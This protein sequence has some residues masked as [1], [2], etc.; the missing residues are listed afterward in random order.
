MTKKYT[1]YITKTVQKQI[2][3]LPDNIADRIEAKMLKL[4]DEPRPQE[5]KKLKGRD[6]YRI[7]VGD[8]R[9][10]YDVQDEILTVEVL[11][12]AHRKDIYK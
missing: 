12:V 4:E 7:K 5:A 9:F 10:I 3:K 8:Y 1:V 11:K 6:A 2:A